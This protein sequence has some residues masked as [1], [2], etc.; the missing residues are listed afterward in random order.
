LTSGNAGKAS[1]LICALSGLNQASAKEGCCRLLFKVSFER[2]FLKKSREITDVLFQY[3][4]QDVK[5]G[6]KTKRFYRF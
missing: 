2:N 3:Q 1:F 4:S 6:Q 5:G